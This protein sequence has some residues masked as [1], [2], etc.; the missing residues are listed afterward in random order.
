MSAFDPKEHGRSP[1]GKLQRG[2]PTD[3]VGGPRDENKLVFDGFHREQTTDWFH[4]T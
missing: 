1:P 3:T 4:L 2:T